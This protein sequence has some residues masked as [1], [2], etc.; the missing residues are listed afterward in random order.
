MKSTAALENTLTF[1][2]LENRKTMKC[3]FCKIE[4]CRTLKS[5]LLSKFCSRACANRHNSISTRDKSRETCLR[6]YGADNPSK[7]AEI[8]KTKIQTCLRNFGVMHPGQSSIVKEKAKDTCIEKYGAENVMQNE[9]I[10]RQKINRFI[11]KYGV[12]NPSKLDSVKLAISEANLQNYKEN[13]DSILL[14]RNQTNLEKYGVEWN[15]QRPEHSVLSKKTS[16]RRYGVDWPMQNDIIN[17]RSKHNSKL[18]KTYIFESGREEKVQGYEPW[19]IDLLLK[20][21]KEDDLVVRTKL[22]PRIGYRFAET[23]RIYRPDIFIPTDNLLIEVKSPY[24]YNKELEKN[25]AKK[26][27]CIKAGYNFRFMIFDKNGKL[28]NDY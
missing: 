20:S 19:A 15:S 22:K 18:L 23:D 6:K 17:D 25:L 12:D 3:Q 1:S 13:K 4:E 21:Y 16:N 10:K 11:E 26:D 14:K 7:S 2:L 27:A 9:D 8:K 24:T 28:L 5:G